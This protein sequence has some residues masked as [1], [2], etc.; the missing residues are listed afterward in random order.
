MDT[1]YELPVRPVITGSNTSLVCLGDSVHLTVSNDTNY[2]YQWYFQDSV[3]PFATD[4][5]Y[6]AFANGDYTVQAMNINGCVSIAYP[7]TVLYDD[8]P[9]YINSSGPT[10]FCYGGEITLTISNGSDYIWSNGDTTQYTVI[11]TSG[12]YYVNFNDVYG[13]PKTSDTVIVAILPRP[14]FNLGNDTLL[15]SG[16]SI[17]LDPGSGYSNYLWNNGTTDQTLV[18]IPD[19]PLPDTSNTYVFVV[20]SNGCPG[21]DTIQVIFEI[22]AGTGTISLN[23]SVVY[24]NLLESGES[25]HIRSGNSAEFVLFDANGQV[26]IRSRQH[27]IVADLKKGIYTYHLLDGNVNSYG[28]IIVQ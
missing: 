5:F 8:M 7:N 4:T 24:P 9:E 23:K 1:I 11:D 2:T 12:E 10:S 26:I 27:D 19:G 18:L 22:C 20:D 13:C 15:C 21:S 25:I 14:V 3:I 6:Y 28:K 16:S 17:T